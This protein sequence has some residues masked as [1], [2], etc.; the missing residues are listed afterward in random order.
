MIGRLPFCIFGNGMIR[1][2]GLPPSALTIP[3]MHKESDFTMCHMN[4]WGLCQNFEDG[5]VDP[6]DSDLLA[7]TSADELRFADYRLRRYRQINQVERY[8]REKDCRGRLVREH[9]GDP[10]EADYRCNS[11]DLCDSSIRLVENEPPQ[12]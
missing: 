5:G 12:S 11:C 8:A 10:V 6:K 3:D 9:F 7:A 4:K 2:E 1:W